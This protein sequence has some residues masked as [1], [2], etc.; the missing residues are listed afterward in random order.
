MMKFLTSKLGLTLTSVL[1]VLGVLWIIGWFLAGIF[2][3]IFKIGLPLLA[4][5][6]AYVYI[7]RWWNDGKR[8]IRDEERKYLDR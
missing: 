1:V 2:G 7:R 5:F 6:V 4:A 3:L 8:E